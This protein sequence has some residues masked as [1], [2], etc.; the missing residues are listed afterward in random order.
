MTHGLPFVKAQSIGNDF[1]LVRTEELERCLARTDRALADVVRALCSRRFGVGSDGL[2]AYRVEGE[3]V[4]QRMFNP[5]GT[6]DFC[7]NGLRCTAARAFRERE[8]PREFTFHH[9]GLKVPCIVT[10]NGYVRTTLAAARW[11]AEEVPVL[12]DPRPRPANLE[13]LVDSLEGCG[14]EPMQTRTVDV[15]TSRGQTEVTLIAVNTGSTHAVVF[16]DELPG[17]PWF[18]E[19]SAQIEVHPLFPERTSVIWTRVERRNVLRLRIWERG[20]GETL[21]CGTGS[22][23]AAVAYL[24][25]TGRW[26][27]GRVRVHNP[28]GSLTFDLPEGWSGPVTSI[29][30]AETLFEGVWTG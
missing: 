1:V 18:T 17:D 10:R 6:E 13:G 21:G 5:D 12:A 19:A 24:R 9:L 30:R 28:G 22:A 23:A 16:V 25:R 20:A 4:H 26:G 8:V 3:I 14:P 7:G 2:L 11:R 15:P 29:G 27:H